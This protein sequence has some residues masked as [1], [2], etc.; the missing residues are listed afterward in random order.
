MPVPGSELS[1]RQ[2]QKL[3]GLEPEAVPAPGAGLTP[4]SRLPSLTEISAAVG[5]VVQGLSRSADLLPVLEEL[6][7]SVAMTQALV[8]R[9]HFLHYAPL[10]AIKYKHT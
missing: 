7:R 5:T 2:R 1:L 9:V 4:P 6:N 10:V 3:S 8:S